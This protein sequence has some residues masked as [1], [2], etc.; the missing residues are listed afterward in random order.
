MSRDVHFCIAIF[1]KKEKSSTEEK[2]RS[3]VS[4]HDDSDMDSDEDGSS[5]AGEIMGP[6]DPSLKSADKKLIE[7]PPSPSPPSPPLSSMPKI[8]PGHASIP[9][10]MRKK[11]PIHGSS[12]WNQSLKNLMKDQE[13]TKMPLTQSDMNVGNSQFSASTMLSS[14]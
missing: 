12:I 5:S 13:V 1:L 3:Y 10:H 14:K 11:T 9:C 6:Q 2:D 4:I 7:N 8:P